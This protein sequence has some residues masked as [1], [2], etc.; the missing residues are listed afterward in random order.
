MKQEH[1]IETEN[2][3]SILHILKENPKR[4]RNCCAPFRICR[5]IHERKNEKEC[6]LGV[7]KVICRNRKKN[8]TQG[9]KIG[10]SKIYVEENEEKR[11]IVRTKKGFCVWSCEQLIF[12]LALPLRL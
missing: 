7:S 5:L 1:K 3:C 9:M 4:K 10:L 12:V 8:L 11:R 2:K 6:P